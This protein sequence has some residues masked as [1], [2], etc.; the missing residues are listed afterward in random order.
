VSPSGLVVRRASGKAGVIVPYSRDPRNIPVPVVPAA[1][2][3]RQWWCRGRIGG[4][5]GHKRD[6]ECAVAGAYV[7]QPGEGRLI[8]L[9]GFSMTVK[10][11]AEGTDGDVLN[12]SLSA[13]TLGTSTT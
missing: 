7:L 2:M 3:F 6:H 4:G 9:G 1:I 13:S 5:V 11:T 12:F 10:A 8:D